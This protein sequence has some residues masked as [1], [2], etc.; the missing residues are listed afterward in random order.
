M[1]LKRTKGTLFGLWLLLTNSTAQALDNAPPAL[2]PQHQGYAFD[3]PEILIR[4]RLFGLAHGVHLLVSVCLDKREYAVATQSAYDRWHAS[5]HLALSTI[6]AD[7]SRYYFGEHAAQA[8]WQD[9]AN[10]LG[11]KETIH[12]S[13]G[14]VSLDD[15]CT[16]L[17]ASL[18]NERYDLAQRLRLADSAV[19][20]AP[21]FAKPK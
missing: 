15:A 7:L 6:R 2:T 17:P 9:I 1:D 11:L 12:P 10:A 8:Y 5:Q 20:P 21:T 4:Q 19:P 16:S 3:Q 13:L 18:D 14:G